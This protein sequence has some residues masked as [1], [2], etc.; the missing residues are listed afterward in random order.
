[1]ASDR[2]TRWNVHQ[3]SP[4]DQ[5]QWRR[6]RRSEAAEMQA[7]TTALANSFAAVNTSYVQEQGNLYSKIAMNR[8]SRTA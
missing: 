8:I 6:D 7:K 2:I 3:L 5:I 1:M 4:Y